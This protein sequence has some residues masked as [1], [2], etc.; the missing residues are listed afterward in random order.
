MATHRSYLVVFNV[1]KKQNVGGLIR[2]ANAFGASEVVVVGR[3][4]FRE[5][6]ACGTSTGVAKR[7]FYRLGDA[8]AHLRDQG[9]AICGVEILDDAVSVERHPFRG[10]TAFLVG[11]EGDGLSAAQLAQCDHTVY[12]PQYGTGASL[13]VNVATAV[14]LH[15]FALW[16][17]FDESRRVGSKFQGAPCE[18][19]DVGETGDSSR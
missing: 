14:V 13:N 7:H 16:A 10:S 9:C 5:L 3:R 6:G 1:A 8:C 12:V 18:V 19:G 15:H 2:T 17:G 4:A 11:N